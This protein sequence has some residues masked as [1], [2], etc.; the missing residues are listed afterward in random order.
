VRARR[1]TPARS[2]PDRRKVRVFAEAKAKPIP[3][4]RGR[5]RGGARGAR[6]GRGG[7]GRAHAPI[8]TASTK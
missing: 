7:A 6:G 1:L 3:T 5:G 2:L 4:G 8:P